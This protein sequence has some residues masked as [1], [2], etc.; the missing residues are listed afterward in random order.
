MSDVNPIRYIAEPDT[1][2]NIPN[3]A[4][5][6]AANSEA[7]HRLPLWQRPIVVN[8]HAD[9]DDA[10]QEQGR[11]ASLKKAECRAR[12]LIVPY[13]EQMRDNLL[14]CGRIGWPERT[15]DHCFGDLV[16]DDDDHR[17]N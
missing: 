7:E 8:Q 16:N 9:H 6:H 1:I 17:N 10:D 2:N 12:V 5:E 11:A 3:R 14:R 13:I 4:T 15:D